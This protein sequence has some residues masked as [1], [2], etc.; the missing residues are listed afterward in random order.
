MQLYLNCNI[1]NSLTI[2]LCIIKFKYK[3]WD[4]N[5]NP[6][7]WHCLIYRPYCHH[8]YCSVTGHA[9]SSLLLCQQSECSTA[10]CSS[11]SLSGAQFCLSGLWLLDVHCSAAFSSHKPSFGRQRSEWFDSTSLDHSTFALTSALCAVQAQWLHTIQIFSAL[12]RLAYL[13]PP[14][15]S[16][17]P[18]AVGEALARAALR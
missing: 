17:S 16:Q 8:R 7:F 13:R 11:I 1:L 10:R 2:T 5:F 9:A 15:T 6:T 14:C 12:H 4:K 18:A 3:K